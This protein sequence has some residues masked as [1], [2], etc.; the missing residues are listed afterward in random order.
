MK[1]AVEARTAFIEPGSGLVVQ[2][3]NV[4]VAAMQ[5]AE[6]KVWAHRSWRVAMRR[7]SFRCSDLLGQ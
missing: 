5:T 4:T 1:A 7:P 6:K 2:S 3:R